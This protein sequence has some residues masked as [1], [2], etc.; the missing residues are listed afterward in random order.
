MMD[1][2]KTVASVLVVLVVLFL[3]WRS[4]R[5]AMTT[6]EPRTIPIDLAELDGGYDDDADPDPLE[7]LAAADLR[8]IPAGPSI[9]DEIAG[10]IDSQGEDMAGL[11]RGWMAER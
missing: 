10:M 2:V 8:Q 1:L 5:K 3:A 11:L 9:S 7:A 4:A 6:R